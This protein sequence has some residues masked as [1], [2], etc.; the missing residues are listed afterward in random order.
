MKYMKL[1]TEG[2]EYT[3]KF[4]FPKKRIHK[5]TPKSYVILSRGYQGRFFN[6]PKVGV[7][8]TNSSIKINDVYNEPVI[9]MEITEPMWLKL[10]NDI[11]SIDGV[12]FL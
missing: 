5:E 1:F 11:K 10:Q 9:E 2:V 4:V 3:K 12:K 8:A 7:K 6:I